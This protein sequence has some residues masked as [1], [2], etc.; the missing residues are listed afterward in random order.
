MALFKSSRKD[1][2]TDSNNMEEIL[3]RIDSIQSDVSLIR[4]KVDLMEEILS[5]R[6]PQDVL[7]ER[8]FLEEIE[9][10]D[11][12]VESIIARIHELKDTVSLK[13]SIEEKLDKKLGLKPS[14]IEMKRIEKVAGLLQKHGKLTCTD[15][16]KL[17]NLSR[18]R[19]N[20]YFKQMEELG[21]VKS[22]E[23]GR[24]KLYMLA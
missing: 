6:L 3:R 11:D 24:K 12:I 16:S 15:L 14:P 4:R 5:E 10:S 7:T 8:K 13:Q 22:A 9:G 20:E 17:L 19:C 2:D 18:T 23:E 1:Q 21:M